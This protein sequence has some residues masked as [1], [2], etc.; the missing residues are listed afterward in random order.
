MRSLH[1][2]A[3]ETPASYPRNLTRSAQP[4][5]GGGGC[6]YLP[7]QGSGCCDLAWTSSIGG[8]VSVGRLGMVGSARSQHGQ[9]DVT[10][11]P[12]EADDGCVVSLPLGSFTVVEG[13]RGGVSQ[14]SEGGEEHRVFESVIAAA[15]AGLA[16][17]AGAELAGHRGE[18]DIAGEPRAVGETGAVTDL[19]E[20]PRSRPRPDP[21]KE[22]RG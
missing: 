11:V 2:A 1:H 19:R 18:A 21:R 20:D 13:S 15:A 7:C 10:P 4:A 3:N 16:A 6:P 8:R 9:D 5:R 12:R 17:D 14:R 22:S